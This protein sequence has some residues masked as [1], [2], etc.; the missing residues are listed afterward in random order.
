[1]KKQFKRFIISATA[2]TLAFVMG[3][4]TVFATSIDDLKNEKTQLQSSLNSLQSQ[5]TTLM[6]DMD[7][8]ERSMAAKGEEI[9]QAEID[10]EEAK[11]TE[12]KQY[13]AMKSRIAMIYEHGYASS[14]I[15][16][17]FE[18]EDFADFLNRAEMA[19]QIY[20]YDK[21]MLNEYKET[22]K[23][24]SELKTRLEA[25]FVEMQNMAESYSQKQASLDNLIIE[26][27]KELAD[28][29]EELDEAIRKAAEEA[30]RK[31]AEEA[32]RK[33]AE[34]K[35]REEAERKAREEAA[36]K[37]AEEAAK[38]EESNK[39]EEDSSN[40]NDSNT[41]SNN[42][43]TTS[44]PVGN[45]S[46][47]QTIVNAAYS[48]LGVPYVWGG[49]SPGRG[50]DC[51]GLTQYCHKV[52]GISIPRVSG[53]QARSGKA[54]NGLANALPGDIICYPGHVAIYIGNGQM[55]HAPQTGDVVKIASATLGRTKPIT[56]IR[57][58]W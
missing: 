10:L 48:Q 47:A 1:M 39:K 13:E 2:M 38:R 6:S 57:R 49:T 8:L 20:D 23:Q 40:K 7:K 9:A 12:V 3:T 16:I 14:Y 53:D 24:I 33:E 25:D 36:R 28:C 54:V 4:S 15:A 51:S 41:N 35:A 50:L 19:K 34:R 27:E 29:Q 37:E 22:K 42:D 55:I 26:K 5:L 43:S 52:A 46:K 32:A 17:L 45:Q 44:A 58:Y 30:A 21:N 56:T 31:A 18:A 11:K